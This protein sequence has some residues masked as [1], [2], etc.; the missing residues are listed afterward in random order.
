M[1]QITVA[2]VEVAYLDCGEGQPVLLVHGF[3]L[4]HSIW[5]SQLPA[6]APHCRAIAP[7]LR[8]FGMTPLGAVGTPVCV[9]MEQYADDLAGLLDALRIDQP[10]VFCGFSM[11]GYIAWQ[12]V[13]KY[14]DRLAGLVLCDTRAQADAEDARD[15][16]L[17]MADQV[18]QWGSE[19]VA[20]MMEPKLVAQ[21][22]KVQMP[23]LIETLRGVM[24]RS[25][26]GAIAAA[27]RGMAARPDMTALL[28]HINVPS[29]VV[30][31][32]ED[33]LSP[34]EEMRSMADAIPN[35]QFVV[36]PSA[37]HMAPMENPRE[38]NRQLL[39]FLSENFS[40]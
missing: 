6:L 3:P 2:D 20:E 11:G 23:E 18:A 8:G 17:K 26:P 40:R 37:G 30:V 36:I 9:A 34:P 32:A 1:N 5:S 13:R 39:T 22:S 28:P 4:D 12:F 33:I 10:I 7:D 15:V 19:V 21:Q 25:S 24:S 14:A 27:Q 31:G 29:L 35:A 38:F 16:R